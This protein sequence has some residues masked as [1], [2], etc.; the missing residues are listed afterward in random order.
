MATRYLIPT[1]EYEYV[2]SFGTYEY[3]LEYQAHFKFYFEFSSP[4]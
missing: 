1:S 2:S 3:V 4:D